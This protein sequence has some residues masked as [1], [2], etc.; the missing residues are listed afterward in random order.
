MDNELTEMNLDSDN[1]VVMSNDLIKSKSN[2]NLNEVKLLRICIMQ[3]IKE[4]KDFQ[5]Y[6]VNITDL[7]KML[8]IDRHGIYL[9]I[10]SMTTNLLK[11]VV[12][13]GDGNPKHKWLKFQWVSRCKY[14]NGVLEIRLHD[15]LKPY[16][17][18]LSKYYTQYVLQDVLLLKSV[19][20]IRLYELIRQEMRYEVFA[21]RTATVYLSLDT[22]RKATDT[23]NKYEKLSM[24]RARVIDSS[25]KEIRE[26][27]GYDIT[28]TVKKQSRQVIGFNFHIESVNNI[29]QQA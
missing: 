1:W 7:A 3:V 26:K 21:S 20:S 13:V 15:D 16:I 19:Y 24:F 22:I 8:N 25:I 10:D 5:T 28:Y 29:R 2:L 14:E 9:T 17:I 11:E 23:E 18:G 27:L 6:K 12:F 4:A